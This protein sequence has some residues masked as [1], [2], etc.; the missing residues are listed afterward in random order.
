M[1]WSPGVQ[2]PHG[3][4]VTGNWKVQ[5]LGIQSRLTNMQSSSRA[6]EVGER[7]Y[8]LGNDLY[9]AMLD[10]RLN[11]TCAYW[12]DACNLDEAQE[13]KLDLVCRKI[14]LKEGMHVLEFGCGWGSLRQ[15]CRGKIRRA[16]AGG[17]R[18]QGAGGAGDGT[19]Q[20]AAGGAALQDYR[21]VQGQYDA[22][23]SIGIMEHVGYK[24]YRTYMQVAD[25]C[26]KP[27]GHRLHPHHWRQHQRDLGG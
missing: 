14:G 13:A 27:G 15:I 7:H 5:L 2:G 19:L 11:Y 20:R 25:R 10:K 23:I 6:Y 8:D 17:D 22:V 26:L 16:R 18:V 3:Y 4:N 12:K 21:E 1:R 24:N 9:E